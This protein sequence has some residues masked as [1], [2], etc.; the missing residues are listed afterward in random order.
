V[1]LGAGKGVDILSIVLTLVA[2]HLLILP[3]RFGET[4]RNQ[5]T[6]VVVLRLINEISFHN[7]SFQKTCPI[8]VFY[9]TTYSFLS[10]RKHIMMIVSMADNV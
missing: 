9:F 8:T 2:G 1:A 7:L 10:K 6:L 3:D 5:R 4:R